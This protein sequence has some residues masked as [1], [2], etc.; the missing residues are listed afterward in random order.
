[1]S[2]NKQNLEKLITDFSEQKLINFLKSKIK[3]LTTEEKPIKFDS[4]A[5]HSNSVQLI[6]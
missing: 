2:F 6:N 4:T 3:N 1:M 5:Q